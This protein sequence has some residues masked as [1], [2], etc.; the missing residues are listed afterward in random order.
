MEKNQIISLSSFLTKEFLY[1]NLDDLTKLIYSIINYHLLNNQSKTT[2]YK[3]DQVEDSKI[4]T[5]FVL[6]H[7]LKSYPKIWSNHIKIIKEKYPTAIIYA[8][9]IEYRGNNT[10]KSTSEGVLSFVKQLDSQYQFNNIVFIGTSNGNRII[11][12]VRH[13][14]NQDFENNKRLVKMLIISLAGFYH[15]VPLINWLNQHWISKKVLHKL[16][17]SS[18][19]ED[20]CK[21]DSFDL[22]WLVPED[23]FYIG[24]YNDTRL[25]PPKS[26]IP[27]EL[28]PKFWYLDFFSGHGSIVSN[29]IK[30]QFEWLNK[31]LTI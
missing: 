17:H 23:T 30:E 1:Y 24:A 14:L 27:L 4:T 20:Y 16:Y 18:I 15:G 28:N 2:I 12:Y 6:L 26:S 22:S 21:T 5:L 25:I 13:Y 9:E 29:T 31:K 10:L 8:P 7:G 3:N 11:H 19:I